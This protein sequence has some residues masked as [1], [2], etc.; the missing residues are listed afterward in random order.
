MGV[1]KRDPPP[2]TR[3]AW[4]ISSGSNPCSFNKANNVDAEGA[5]D[6]AILKIATG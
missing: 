6:D 2:V 1:H 3:Q 5:V 4:L